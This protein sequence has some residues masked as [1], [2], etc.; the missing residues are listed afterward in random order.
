MPEFVKRL[1]DRRKKLG[2]SLKEAE[3]ATKIRRVHLKAIEEGNFEQ[4]KQETH[5]RGFLK[6]YCNYLGLDTEEILADYN[7]FKGE[8]EGEVEQEVTFK[9]KV[10]NKMD[11]NQN[12]LLVLTLVIFGLFVVGSFSFLGSRVYYLISSEEGDFDFQPV[13]KIQQVIGN[14]EEELDEG[15]FIQNLEEDSNEDITETEEVIEVQ[16]SEIDSVVKEE[17]DFI[18]EQIGGQ[19]EFSQT[20]ELELVI[21]TI[22]D[23]WY[24]V[25]VDGEEVFEGFTVTEEANSFSGRKIEVRI[26]NAA[27]VV[28]V[29]DGERYG[30]FGNEGEVVTQVFSAIEDNQE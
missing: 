12:K 9:G 22:E 21:E 19:K 1:K 23:T 30:P 7:K 25:T 24:L 18:E 3:N 11:Q 17:S 4:I 15:E 5:I 29:K 13:Q 20:E 2:V 16:E 8:L 10:I 26:G 6:V 28:V 27:G 14:F